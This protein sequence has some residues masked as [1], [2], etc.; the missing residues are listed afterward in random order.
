VA[1]IVMTVAAAATWMDARIKTS[2]S[3]APT[4]K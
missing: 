1:L 3:L 4:A 2:R